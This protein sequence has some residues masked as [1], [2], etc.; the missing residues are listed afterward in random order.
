MTKKCFSLLCLPATKSTRQVVKKFPFPIHLTEGTYLDVALV[1][2]KGA[3]RVLRRDVDVSDFSFVWL[4]SDWNSRDVAY[5]LRLYFESTDTPHSYVEKSPSK[6]TDYMNFALNNLLIPDTVFV[7]R[8]NLE[9][10]LPRI[11]KV[12]GYPLVIKDV[13]GSKG[14]HSQYVASEADLLKKMKDLPKSKKFLFQR[15]ISSEFD[16]GVMVA[17]GIVVAGE[18][19]YPS[20]GESGN[21][22]FTRPEEHFID[23]ADI[24]MDI[25]DMAIKASGLL[26]LSWSR[27]DIII[28]KNTGLPYLLE[29][30]RY[31]GITSGSSEVAGAYTFLASHIS[32]SLSQ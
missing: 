32:P 20:G 31:P 21:T 10:S 26:N 15:Y 19:T 17:N 6:V 28:D 29:V 11:K 8:T 27:V 22:I 16:W 4:A 3:V 5:A 12:C 23:V 7:S 24:P 18:K 2:Y 14:K 1:F 9:K 30:N 13:K 25:K